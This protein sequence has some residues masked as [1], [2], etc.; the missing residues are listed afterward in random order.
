MKATATGYIKH[1]QSDELG[2]AL[3][4]LGGGREVKGEQIDHAVG[5]VL[6]KKVGDFVHVGDTIA[7]IHANDNDKLNEAVKRVASAYEYSDTAV[8][9]NKLIRGVIM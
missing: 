7:F 8:E 2:N 3:V 1:I 4:I 6:N 9:R 5:I